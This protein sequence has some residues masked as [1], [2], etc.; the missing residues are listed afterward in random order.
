MPEGEEKVDYS[1]Q[2]MEGFIGNGMHVLG[3]ADKV[4][5]L[6][7][8]QCG[9]I[10]LISSK[11]SGMFITGEKGAGVAMC[12]NDG[13]W[14]API[15]VTLDTLGW[16][17]AIGVAEKDCLILL[18]HFAMKR[19][20]EGNFQ[21]KL[22]LDIGLA[23]GAIGGDANADMELSEKAGVASSFGYTWEKGLML[24]VEVKTG[25]VF[26]EVNANKLFY[27][28]SNT[29]EILGG[30]VKIPNDSPVNNLWAKLAELEG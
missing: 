19:L 3:R 6:L 11:E 4:P 7:F 14:S 30:K 10:L 22:G 18:N 9:G 17:A 21:A 24:N 1:P 15:A 23:V 20:L 12:R 25:T 8:K 29:S 28:T 13:K 2:F 27:K 26:P 16:G 5:K